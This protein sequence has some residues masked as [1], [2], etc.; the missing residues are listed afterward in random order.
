MGLKGRL[1]H[2]LHGDRDGSR[3]QAKHGALGARGIPPAV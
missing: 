3:S 1:R 2:F